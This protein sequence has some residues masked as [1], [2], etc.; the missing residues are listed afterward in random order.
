ML[1]VI[2]NFKNHQKLLE[3]WFTLLHFKMDDPVARRM[4][5]N[6]PTLTCI[7]F[8]FS[9]PCSGKKF[10]PW[11]KM[12]TWKMLALICIET[13]STALSFYRIGPKQIWTRTKTFWCALNDFRLDHKSLF[14]TELQVLIQSKFT[15]DT[16]S[17]KKSQNPKN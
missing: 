2:T 11:K 6:N 16:L 9:S 5:K 8:F 1:K 4:K 14:S 10:G 3:Y 17:S 12:L 7:R 15:F 13:N